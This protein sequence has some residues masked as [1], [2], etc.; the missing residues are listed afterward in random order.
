MDSHFHMTEYS[1][2]VI[3]AHKVPLRNMSSSMSVNA[4][5]LVM[6]YIRAKI[7]GTKFD[8]MI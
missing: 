5:K 8:S 2:A 3:S 7:K 4:K 6:E 1:A